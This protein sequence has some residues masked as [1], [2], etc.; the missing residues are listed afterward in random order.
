MSNQTT[1]LLEAF[2]SLPE[3]EKRLFTAAFLKRAM[4]YDSG[5][6]EDE[7]AVCAADDLFAALDAEE[8]AKL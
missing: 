4:P 5:P 8:N 6:Y 3:E 7:E 1:A 2:E